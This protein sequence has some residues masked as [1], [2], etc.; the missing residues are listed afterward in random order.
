MKISIIT[1]SYNAVTTIEETIQSVLNQSYQ[2]IEYVIIDGG[3]SDGT[4]AIIEK[5]ADKIAFHVSEPDGGIY[6]GMNKGIAACTGDY[7]GILNADDVYASNGIIS[8][9]VEL[10]QTSKSSTLYGDLD[11]VAED[12]LDDVVRKWISGSFNR[13]SFLMGWMPP[14]PTFFVQKGLYDKYGVFNTSFKISADYELMLRF[15]FKNSLS[16]AY[17]PQTLIKM[18]VGGVSNS[19]I[20]NR[21]QANKEDRKAWKINGLRPKWF[22]LLMKPASKVMQFLKK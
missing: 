17:L 18:R 1:V 4:Q 21:L 8:K 11:Y 12:N 22:T 10:L 7:I 19:S 13:K 15:L 2:H 9:V 16:A 5:Y 14:H 3:S 20:K 6:F